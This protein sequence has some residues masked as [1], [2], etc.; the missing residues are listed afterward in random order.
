MFTHFYYNTCR[1]MTHA[2]LMRF[3]DS[4]LLKLKADIIF[5]AVFINVN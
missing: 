5:L 2:H 3:I 1:F 4:R